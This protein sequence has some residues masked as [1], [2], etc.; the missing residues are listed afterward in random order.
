[1]IADAGADEVD[2][3]EPALAGGVEGEVDAGMV[4]PHVADLEEEVFA[5]GEGDD[6]LEVLEVVGGGF[7]EVKVLAG[8]ED[9]EAVAGVVADGG[10]DG[11]DLDA[12]VGEEGGA[13]EDGNIFVFWGGLGD[14]DELVGG[15]GEDGFDFAFTVGVGGAEEAD[16][17]GRLGGEGEEEGAAG[18]HRYY[19]IAD[20]DLPPGRVVRKGAISWVMFRAFGGVSR[21]DGGF[22][23]LS[24]NESQEGS[25]FFSTD[26]GLFPPFRALGGHFRPIRGRLPPDRGGRS[27]RAGA[28]E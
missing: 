16:A 21:G 12:G 4:A 14:A 9:S 27:W 7:F 23:G 3:A 13:G 18:E 24:W 25:P 8:F 6:F 28:G 17:D 15:V 20:H 11:D 22:L 5:L 2:I 1:M 26:L 19:D 10:F